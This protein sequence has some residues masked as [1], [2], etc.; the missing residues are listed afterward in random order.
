MLRKFIIVCLIG[1]WTFAAGTSAWAASSTDSRVKRYKDN[2]ADYLKH[3]KVIADAF[4][5]NYNNS[6]AQALVARAIWYMENGYMIYGHHKYETT[7]YIDCS[8]FT[9]LVYRDFGYTITS[10][11]KKYPEVGKKVDGVYSRQVPGSSTYELV[12]IEKL[13]PGDIFTFWKKDSTG[14]GTH[15]GH[16]ALYIGNING[17]PAIIHTI[18][19]RPTAIGITNSFKYWYGE[20]FVEA[21]RILDNA[22]FSPQKPWQVP[23]PVIPDKYQLPPQKPIIQPA[24]KFLSNK[25]TSQFMDIIGHWAEEDIRKLIKSGVFDGYPDG[26]FRPEQPISR[27][28]FATALV[29]AF[30]ISPKGGQ[31]FRD[32][33]SHWAKDYIAAAAAQ[34]IV[35]GYTTSYFGPD[36]PITREQMAVMVMKAAQIDTEETDTVKT[37]YA[38][39]AF[40]SQ[41]AQ[42]AVLAA[43]QKGI[44]KGYTNNTYQP[45]RG[46]NRAEAAAVIS[47][48]LGL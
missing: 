36:D 23:L 20:H 19:G 33:S 11:S 5:A 15:I 39:Q 34:D 45:K 28:E 48:A 1:L 25:T 21:R 31:I 4:L 14:S 32:T 47:R 37:V 43:E 12:G 13:Q 8:I 22:S 41:W 30:D 3:D 2:Y 40:I 9:A 17:K 46:A 27:A 7:G 44:I 6:E 10:A 18:S 29:A 42:G 24:Q 38:D 35:S 16:V 26:T